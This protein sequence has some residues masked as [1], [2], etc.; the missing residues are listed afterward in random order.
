M[1]TKITQLLIIAILLQF[2]LP[3]SSF[4]GDFSMKKLSISQHQNSLDHYSLLDT[5][6][7]LK[8]RK[9]HRGGGGRRGRNCYDAGTTTM[10]LGY[11]FP[12][13][14][15]L[16]WGSVYSAYEDVEVTG[17]GP[18]HFKAEYGLSEVV[19]LG[20]SVGY[21]HTEWNWTY[22]ASGFEYVT[23]K[24]EFGNEITN[25]QYVPHQYKEG[26]VYSALNINA[27]VNFHFLTTQ[28]LDPY[29]GVGLGY[30]KPTI[31]FFSDDPDYTYTETIS[32][33]IPVGF[34]STLGLRYYFTPNI[35]L[36][37]EAGLS[38]SIMQAG[39]SIKF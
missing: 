36:Y 27:R 5:K 12:N 13:L 3:D 14:T 30:N 15:K 26:V 25:Y 8:K 20:V 22:D 6:D 1:K 2:M 19:S 16:V 17:Y 18:L 33:P 4:A 39:L 7:V 11:G 35:G 23:S 31:T 29:F 38:K 34:E 37:A 10:T 32:S 24:D 28:Q 21:V 9:K